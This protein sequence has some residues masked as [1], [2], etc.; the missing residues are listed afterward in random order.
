MSFGRTGR[1]FSFEHADIDPDLVC[2]GKGLSAGYLPVSSAVVKHYIY[3][4]F[5]DKPEDHT[6]YH[7]HTFSPQTLSKPLRNSAKT[8]ISFAA[9]PLLRLTASQTRPKPRVFVH[10]PLT[11][12]SRHSTAQK[13]HSPPELPPCR[14]HARNLPT[15]F[16]ILP[17]PSRTTHSN[18][19]NCA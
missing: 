10:R 14:Q 3:E 5:T 9:P 16:S 8:A 17:E 12:L 15:R 19:I 18:T 7:G 4:T 11:W 13:Q 6:F 2:L 1:M